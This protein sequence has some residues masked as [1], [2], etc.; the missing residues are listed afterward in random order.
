[1]SYTKDQQSEKIEVLSF[2]SLL[3][4]ECCTSSASPRSPRRP[5]PSR[6]PGLAASGRVNRNTATAAEREALP[7]IGPSL[8][9]WIIAGRPYRS[10]EDLIEVE[11]IGEKKLAVLRPRVTVE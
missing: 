7:G 4:P 8:A 9:R 11:G 10:V 5:T 3:E 2:S 6:G 1:V